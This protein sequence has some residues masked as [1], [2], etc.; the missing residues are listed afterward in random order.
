MSLDIKN[1]IDVLSDGVIVL[2]N[3]QPVLINRIGEMLW[4]KYGTDIPEDIPVSLNGKYYLPK[5]RSLP[6]C[7][8][9]IWRDVSELEEIKR[10]TVIDP[11][12][13]VFNSRFMNTWLEREF[14]RASRSGSQ[15]GLVLID[16]D[17]GEECKLTMKDIAQVISQSVRGY[18]MVCRSDR[19]DFAIMLFVVDT[20]SFSLAVERIFLAIRKTGL[21]RV[22]VGASLSGRTPSA[23]SMVKQAQR[24]LYVVNIRGGNDFSVS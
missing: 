19:A 1:I 24:A 14:D 9:L 13:G 5:K 3:N 17:I 4:E 6:G 10:I 20:N 23:E 12:T 15:M 2:E 8:V 21:K 16:I 22:S 7:E 11:E 18:D